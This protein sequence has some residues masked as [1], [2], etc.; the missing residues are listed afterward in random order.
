M[1][2]VARTP[3]HH[4]ATGFAESA[5]LTCDQTWLAGR[6]LHS[7]TSVKEFPQW[8]VKALSAPVL[9]CDVLR[10]S[11]SVMIFVRWSA[12]FDRALATELCGYALIVEKSARP[13]FVHYVG[14]GDQRMELLRPVGR[15]ATSAKQVCLSALA[16]RRGAGSARNALQRLC[17]VTSAAKVTIASQSRNAPIALIVKIRFRFVRPVL[18]CSRKLLAASALRLG[19]GVAFDVERLTRGQANLIIA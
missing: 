14:P 9:R 15:Y 11:M 3:T 2:S 5:F 19:M 16:L 1:K 8:P 18:R 6:D 12:S 7:K 10:A 4:P 13:L 17:V